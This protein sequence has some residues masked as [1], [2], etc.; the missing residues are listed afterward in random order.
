MFKIEVI[1]LLV[2]ISSISAHQWTEISGALSD[3]TGSPNY[4]AG[5]TSVSATYHCAQPCNG[6]WVKVTENLRQA[7]AK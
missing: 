7:D 4:L 6:N 1:L 2:F 5:V 3:V